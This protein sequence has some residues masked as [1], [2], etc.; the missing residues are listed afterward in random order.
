MPS[1]LQPALPLSGRPRGGGGGTDPRRGPLPPRGAEPGAQRGA[2]PAAGPAGAGPGAVAAA[3][4][5]RGPISSGRARAGGRGQGPQAG[6]A[7]GRRGPRGWS[8][9]G[10]ARRPDGRTDGQTDG[11]AEA[12]G[13]LGPART[14]RSPGGGGDHR[15]RSGGRGAR[16]RPRPMGSQVSGA[17]SL[18][19][20]PG[21]RI[22]AGPGRGRSEPRQLRAGARPRRLPPRAPC[23]P[24]RGG[25]LLAAIGAPR[26]WL[27]GRR[28]RPGPAPADPRAR[29]ARGGAGGGGAGSPRGCARRRWRR[30]CPAPLALR[31][32]CRRRRDPSPVTS[33]RGIFQLV[34]SAAS[35]P[36]PRRQPRGVLAPPARAVPRAP[37]PRLRAAPGPARAEFAKSRNCGRWARAGPRAPPGLGGHCLPLTPGT[38][39]VSILI[40]G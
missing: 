17:G 33:E 38:G 19:A 5:Q 27:R 12:S 6:R 28:W 11:A 13:Q 31:A 24:P 37:R 3:R 16:P 14:Q 23:A 7:R 25:A 8:G 4:A 22:A 10:G 26:L 1:E 21:R 35:T 40:A 32:S 29:V 34:I 18:S 9:R 36:G 15:R 30:G 20:R 2:G 39:L